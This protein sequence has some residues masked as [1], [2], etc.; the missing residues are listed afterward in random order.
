MSVLIQYCQ[1]C[2]LVEWAGEFDDEVP[3]KYPETIEHLIGEHI[4]DL[5]E[6]EAEFEPAGFCSVECE[7]EY[8]DYQ[9]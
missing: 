7:L 8:N 6:L 5:F 4:Y 9:W 1:E 2:R 3:G